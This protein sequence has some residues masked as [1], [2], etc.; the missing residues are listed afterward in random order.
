[1]HGVVA[2]LPVLEVLEDEDVT[3]PLTLL[4]DEEVTTPLTLDV[5][6]LEE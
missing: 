6:V 2:A 4:E 5:A 1:M 3:T